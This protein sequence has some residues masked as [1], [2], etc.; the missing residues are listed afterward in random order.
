MG[1]VT[2][3]VKAIYT[4]NYIFQ[5]GINTPVGNEIF[6]DYP[7]GINKNKCYIDYTITVNKSANNSVYLKEI[8][9]RLSARLVDNNNPWKMTSGMTYSIVIQFIEFY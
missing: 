6:I 5:S 7:P 3:C 1:G 9:G 8:N 4:E 2:S